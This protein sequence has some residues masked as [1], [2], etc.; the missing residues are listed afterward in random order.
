MIVLIETIQRVN[1]FVIFAQVFNTCG[2]C[3]IAAHCLVGPLVREPLIGSHLPLEVG[4]P[5]VGATDSGCHASSAW[6][7]ISIFGRGVAWSN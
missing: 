4:H 3:L 2:R 6:G 7:A 1:L 5:E